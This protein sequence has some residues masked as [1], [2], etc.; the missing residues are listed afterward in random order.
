MI[1]TLSAVGLSP[2]F[3]EGAGYSTSGAERAHSDVVSRG[4]LAATLS[5]STLMRGPFR[6]FA[7]TRGSRPAERLRSLSHSAL[8]HSM[9]FSVAMHFTISRIRGR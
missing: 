5:Y 2:S 4:S 1:S 8:T 7:L 9:V 3:H 6:T